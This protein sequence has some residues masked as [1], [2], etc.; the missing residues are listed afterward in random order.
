MM[1][2]RKSGLAR[3]TWL[4]LAAVAPIFLALSCDENLPNGPNTFGTTIKIS[5]PHDTLVVGDS[6]V[7]Q[8][9]ATD[10]NGRVIQS[11]S[12]NWTSADSSIVGVAAATTAD[13]TAG[14]TRN[15]IGRR[16]GRSVVTL[17][18]PD[19][20][21]VASNVTRTETVVVGG[22]R[23]LTTHDST[24]TAVN[25]TG[26]A[27]AAGLVRANG[28]LVT[29]VSQGLRWIHLGSHASMVGTGDTI[30]Y[31]ARSN[32]A[33]TLIAT[34]DLCLVSAKCADTVV[35][36]VSQQLS[37]TLSARSFLAWSFSDSVGPS[38]TLADRRGN[39]LAGTSIR[40]IPV[41]PADSAIV[42]ATPSLG[43]SN[44]AT[45]VVA[46][47]KL[48]TIGNGNARVSVFALA[49]DGISIIG[50]DSV[51]V[52]VRQV[53]RR[54]QVEP[55]RSLMTVL[56]SIPIKPLARDARGAE[57]ADATVTVAPSGTTLTSGIWAGP[58]PTAAASTQATITP[59][60]TGVALPVNNPLA[61]QVSVVV[62]PA[63]LTLAV[64]DTVK[65]GTTLKVVSTAV[66]DSNAVAVV[67]SWVRFRASS[68][69]TPDSVQVGANGLATVSWFPPNIIGRYT[70]TGLRGKATP[71]ATLADSA[72]RIVIRRS[73]EVIAS[74]PDPMTSTFAV[75]V[76]P[77][78]M[79]INT[80]ATVTIT[81]KDS[82][83]N[84]VKAA[85][86]SMFTLTM[87]AGAFSAIACGSNTGICTATYTAP[88]AAGPAQIAAKILGVDIFGSPINL[89]ITP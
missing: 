37:L 36:R 8:A 24:L 86:T 22:V 85:T 7:A 43:T 33:D 13:G 74:D 79:A 38:A 31:I 32:G 16:T 78:T 51:T 2:A 63:T 5:V 30:R 50:V 3:R 1:R 12:F 59:T 87:T 58:N 19:P 75:S 69:V 48:V 47:P 20:R 81:L 15:L 68:G 6:S 45:G 53:A 66:L 62:D 82:F 41:A 49:P 26:R 67:G 64:L 23:I 70:L 76:S 29:K 40:F 77:A 34:H 39:G 61:P 89:T 28:A 21:F 52:G 18:L 44:P 73:V 4:A 60:L 10:D 55:L 71:L 54:V 42:K 27:I 9:V 65:A 57:I 83:G 56:D 80:T 72:G 11:L 25:D 84:L 46:I 14:R 17:A 88:A 35:V